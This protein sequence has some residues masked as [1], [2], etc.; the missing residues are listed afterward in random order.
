MKSDRYLHLNFSI[1]LEIVQ[2]LWKFHGSRESLSEYLLSTRDQQVLVQEL[3][4]EVQ[5][6][7]KPNDAITVWYTIYLVINMDSLLCNI[8]DI[9]Q[10]LKYSPL[11]SPGG[12]NEQDH[13]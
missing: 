7:N 11:S 3:E 4:T 12:D 6:T 13:S 5:Y 2:A 10:N 9:F 1:Y 8:I